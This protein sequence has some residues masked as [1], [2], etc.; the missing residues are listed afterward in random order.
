VDSPIA[1]EVKDVYFVYPSRRR[2]GPIAACNG[3]SF[4]VRQGEIFGLFGPNGGGKSTLFK[5]ISTILRPLKGRVAILG[6]DVQSAARNVRRHLGIAFQVPSLDAKLTAEEN[7]LHHGHLYGLHGSDLKRRIHRALDRVN[8]LGRARSLVETLSGGMARRLELAKTLLHEPEVLLLDEPSAGLDPGARTEF[9]EQLKNIQTQSRMTV[10]LTTHL[11]EEA[12][13]C[14]RLALLNR[15]EIVATGSPEQLIAEI[16]GDIVTIRANDPEAL[17]IDIG[18]HFG[19]QPAKMGNRLRFQCDSGHLFI[20]QLVEAFPDK[21]QEISVG[22]PNLDDVFIA[23]TGFRIDD[24]ER[25]STN[26]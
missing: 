9:W 23:R 1:I 22:K 5:I 12:A 6:M 3:I 25:L 21:I 26:I 13:N 16:G 24:P 4:F 17:S 15:G 18:K 10:L 11:M 7:L 14:D 8:L 19:I 2:N 20:P